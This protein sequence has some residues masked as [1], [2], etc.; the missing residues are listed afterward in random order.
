[1]PLFKLFTIILCL[2]LLGC[3]V[4]HEDFVNRQNLMIGKRILVKE[5]YQNKDAGQLF[6]G[7]DVIVGQGLTHITKDDQGNLIYHYSDQEVLASYPQ[8]AW[9]GKCLIYRVVDPKTYILKSWGFDG[10]NP[11]ACRS[12]P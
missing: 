2:G 1:M 5:P 3:V 8:K 11:L 10:G 7:S 9:V 12:W 6:R 4:G